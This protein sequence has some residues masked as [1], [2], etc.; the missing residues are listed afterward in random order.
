M[1]HI[2]NAKYG[3]IMKKVVASLEADGYEVIGVTDD[4]A[5]VFNDDKYEVVSK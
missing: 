5:A 3:N 1:P 2:G 4:Q